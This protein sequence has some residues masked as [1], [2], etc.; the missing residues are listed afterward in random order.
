MK[1]P[2]VSQGLEQAYQEVF[3]IILS[4]QDPITGLFPASSDNNHHGDYTDAWVRDNVYSIQAVWALAL[5]YG[6]Q[7][8]T[9]TEAQRSNKYILEHAV[10]KLMRGLLVSMM[11][12]ADK[13]ESFKRSQHPLDALH[14]KYKTSSG[15]TVVDDD[16]WGHLQFDATAIYLLMLARMTNGGLKI[17]YTYDEVNF[18]QNLVHYIGRAYRT[19]DYGIWERGNKINNGKPE[20]N[21]SSVG[22]VRAALTELRGLN[23]FGEQGDQRSVIHVM[24]DE[25]ARSKTMLDS[26]LPRESLSKQVDSALLSIISYPAFAIQDTSLSQKTRDSIISTLQGEYGLKRF[27]LDGHATA[28]EDT[29]RLHYE[30]DELKNFE[31]IECEWPLFFTYLALDGIYRSDE[32]FTQYYLEK[33]E[34]VA[35]EKNGKR[36]LPEQYYVPLDKIDAEKAKPHSQVRLPNNNVPLI[37]AQSL[38]YIAKFLHKGLIQKEQ[39]VIKKNAYCD[40]QTCQVKIKVALVAHSEFV[41]KELEDYGLKN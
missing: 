5:A 28:L 1:N 16:K 36:L 26:L 29:S 4:R 38:W 12:Q 40:N 18:I 41:S 34:K 15:E 14:A 10:I 33:L 19:P 3:D 13:V 2:T 9:L 35:V 6:N 11:R 17:I 24:T 20:I 32:K 27:L 25:I 23:L 37:W 30:N 22:M 31:S 7:E 39:L 8:T 21:A